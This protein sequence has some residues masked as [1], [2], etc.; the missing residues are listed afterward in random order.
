MVTVCL[1]FKDAFPVWLLSLGHFWQTRVSE[2]TI[3]KF[4]EMEM[5]CV[6]PLLC[7]DQ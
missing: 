4:A 1:K 2:F 5:H 7:A 3:C 6:Y